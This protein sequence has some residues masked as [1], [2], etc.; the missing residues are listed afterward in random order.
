MCQVRDVC[1]VEY[2]LTYTEIQS[3]RYRK[4][5]ACLISRPAAAKLEK[6]LHDREAAGSVDLS[7]GLWFNGHHESRNRD[8]V[9]IARPQRPC[10]RAARRIQRYPASYMYPTLAPVSTSDPSLGRWSCSGK[11][12]ANRRTPIGCR[13]FQISTASSGWFLANPRRSEILRLLV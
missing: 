4:G 1:R 11:G 12:G 3:T 10:T 5:D 13:G 7:R 8:S 2:A 9:Q 6:T